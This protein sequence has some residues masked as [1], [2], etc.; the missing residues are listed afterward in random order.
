VQ[1]LHRAFG[2]GF[3][4]IAFVRKDATPDQLR[5]LSARPRPD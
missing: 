3:L 2:Q 5:P 1:L 4:V